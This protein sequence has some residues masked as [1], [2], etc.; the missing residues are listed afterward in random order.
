MKFR[1]KKAAQR[2]WTLSVAKQQ[3]V[4]AAAWRNSAIGQ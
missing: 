1:K 2:R 3:L 4:V